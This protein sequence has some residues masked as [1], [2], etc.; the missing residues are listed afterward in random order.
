MRALGRFLRVPEPDWCLWQI[1][2]LVR[3]LH[4]ALLSMRQSHQQRDV[5]GNLTILSHTCTRSEV[6][7]VQ[8]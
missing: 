5:R 7:A 3:V 8:Q 1:L 4:C 2:V 6:D